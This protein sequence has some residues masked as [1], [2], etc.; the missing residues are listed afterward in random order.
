MEPHAVTTG[1]A[2]SIMT[3]GTLVAVHIPSYTFLGNCACI[4]LNMQSRQLPCPLLKGGAEGR[5]H[6][7]GPILLGE[8]GAPRVLAL[9]CNMASLYKIVPLLV[10]ILPT[11]D[12]FQILSGLQGSQTSVIVY[13]CTDAAVYIVRWV[14]MLSPQAVAVDQSS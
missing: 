1:T 8:Y 12:V 10:Y 9:C 7:L 5:Q 13:S 14:V 3:K 11:T 4:Q 6:Q 2:C